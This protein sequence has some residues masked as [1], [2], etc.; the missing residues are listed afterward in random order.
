MPNKLWI[1]E[2][3]TAKEA[4]DFAREIEPSSDLYL[5]IY[6]IAPNESWLFVL[7]ICDICKTKDCF[8][9]PAINYENGICGEECSNCGNMS[10]YPKEGNFE[11]E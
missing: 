1:L 5:S 9:T 8:F 4:A 11:N 6:D 10:L 2:F 3:D 7:G